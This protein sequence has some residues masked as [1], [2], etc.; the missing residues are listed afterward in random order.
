MNKINPIVWNYQPSNPTPTSFWGL[1]GYWTVPGGHSWYQITDAQGQIWVSDQPLSLDN[2]G[3][4]FSPTNDNIYSAYMNG[5][6]TLAFI[7]CM[8]NRKINE[9]TPSRTVVFEF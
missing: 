9:D 8:W 6:G 3:N 2:N 1:G 5:D 7:N 4:A